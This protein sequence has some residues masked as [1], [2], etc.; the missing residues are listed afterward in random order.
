MH[1]PPKAKK[2]Q[3]CQLTKLIKKTQENCVITDQM[4]S[5]LNSLGPNGRL[6]WSL[7]DEQQ[8]YIK[9]NYGYT[10]IPYIYRIRTGKFFQNPRNQPA[11]IKE[12][13][14]AAHADQKFIAKTLKKQEMQILDSHKIYYQ[15][16]K[17]LITTSQ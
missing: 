8:F 3:A 6:V 17:Y 16:I 12:L 5:R 15:P 11:I 10:I 14:R 2:H 1:K 4:K 9:K 13:V 7:S